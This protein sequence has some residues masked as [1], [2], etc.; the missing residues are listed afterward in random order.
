MRIIQLTPG[1]GSFYCGTCLRDNALVT[2]MRRQGH[3]AVMVPM[4]LP[5]TLDEAPATGSTPLFYGGVN[6]YLQH[7]AGLFRRTPRWLDKLLDAPGILKAAGKRAGMTSASELADL[8][9]SMLRGEEGNQLKELDRLA[10]WLA[11]EGKPD[12]VCL[13]NILLLGLARRIKQLTGAQ[14]V[15]TLQG[16]DS[17]LDTFPEKERK[18]AWDTLAERAADVDHFIAVSEYYGEVMTRRARL[19]AD[20][21]HVVYNG[22]SL[23]GYAP[24]PVPPDPP[25]LGYLSRMFWGKGLGTLVEAYL[26][27]RER[28]RIP[29]L[30][31][32]VAG[33]KMP[34]DEAFV[35]QMRA[36]LAEKGAEADVEF[37]PNISREEKIAFLQSLS[38]LSV[39]TT[40]GESFGLYLVEAWAAGVPVVQPDHA[41]FPELIA[42]TGGGLLCRPD[43]AADLAAKIEILLLDRQEARR[44]GLQARRV[45]EE[46]FSVE[47]MANGVLA[48]MEGRA[49][50]P[51]AV[52]ATAV[53]Q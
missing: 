23:E 28:G 30:K 41:A 5:P 33:T 46:R 26:L 9:I 37:L 47:A 3:D 53:R 14:V 1:T 15:C 50:R 44:M 43:D 38:A 13:S 49:R 40:Y 25:V 51:F 29:G 21:V 11:A 27:V 45:V 34:A 48:V 10:E 7:K 8:T 22:I 17:F 6:V 36:R 31:L 18:I 4:Y 16:E 2:E 19:P 32:R 12:V 42:A 39:P 52:P 35:Q 20:R 24:A